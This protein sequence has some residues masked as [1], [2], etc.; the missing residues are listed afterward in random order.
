MLGWSGRYEMPLNSLLPQPF[1]YFFWTN[2]FRHFHSPLNSA[3]LSDRIKRGVDLADVILINA[4][5]KASLERFCISCRSTALLTISTKTITNA[6][7]YLQSPFLSEDIFSFFSHFMQWALWGYSA[8]NLISS[9]LKA[10]TE[11]AWNIPRPFFVLVRVAV[12]DSKV[13][14]TIFCILG[15]YTSSL[16]PS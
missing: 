10:S 7:L 14:S 13:S 12:V 2:Q 5:M 16:E 11:I 6:F 1:S 3:V 9:G 4:M 8:H 15:S